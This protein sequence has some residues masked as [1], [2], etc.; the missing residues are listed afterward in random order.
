MISKMMKPMIGAKITMTLSP[1]GTPSNI[2]IPEEM[3]KIMAGNPMT[4]GLGEMFSKDGIKKMMNSSGG[5]F[6]KNAIKAGD[7]W[8]QKTEMDTPF[9]TMKNKFTYTYK[10]QNSDGLEE[11]S[12]KFEIETKP[13]ENAPFKMDMKIKESKGTMLFD[14]KA[15]RITSS[16]IEFKMENNMTIGPNVMKQEM[17]N[18]TIFKLVAPSKKRTDAT[19]E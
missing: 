2:K 15:G 17:V 8:K 12:P 13:K 9:A 16:H 5:I 6:P 18:T 4:K 14:N 11:I 3:T 1:N 19:K 7:S 10:G